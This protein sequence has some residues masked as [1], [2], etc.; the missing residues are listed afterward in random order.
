MCFSATAS[1]VAGGA[2]SLLGTVTLRKARCRAEVPL[3]LIPLLFGIQQIIEGAL[4]LSFQFDLPQIKTSMTYAFT[5]FSHVLWPIF[6]PLAVSMVE[7]DARRKKAIYAF[8]LIGIVVAL[9]LLY[10][11]VSYPVIA[12][13]DEHIV[14]ASPH[15]YKVPVMLLY[16]AA[17]CMGSLFSSHKLINTFGLTAFI[18]F[19]IAYWFY[20]VAFFSVWCFFAA[21]LS[22]ILYLYFNLSKYP[23]LE[24]ANS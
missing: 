11:I 14:Y 6:V 12:E 7:P 22:A 9:Y 10:L 21:I 18:L 3:A 20:T 2:L 8:L 1:F 16:L 13:I 4:W 17:T 23:Q 19:G 15:F 24:V 5:L